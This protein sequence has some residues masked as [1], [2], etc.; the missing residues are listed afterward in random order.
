MLSVVKRHVIKVYKSMDE[1]THKIFTHVGVCMCKM[2]IVWV[3]F[4][5]YILKPH[6]LMGKTD[7]ARFVFDFIEIE[8]I[9]ICDGIACKCKPKILMFGEYLKMPS[10]ESFLY[11]YY[12]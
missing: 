6:K 2:H 1:C 3:A 10:R 4:T 9:L 5:S 7:F 11:R 12:W 8:F